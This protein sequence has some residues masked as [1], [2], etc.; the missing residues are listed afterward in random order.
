MLLANGPLGART[1]KGHPTV[2]SPINKEVRKSPSGFKPLHN[3]VRSTDGEEERDIH[4]F[5]KD[6]RFVQ[7]I[8]FIVRS[9]DSTKLSPDV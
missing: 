3:I 8:K 4:Y 1:R 5:L 6:Q 9:W 2:I 7:H